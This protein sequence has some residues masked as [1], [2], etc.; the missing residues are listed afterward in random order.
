MPAHDRLFVLT[1]EPAQAH[2]IELLGL[3]R[4]DTQVPQETDLRRWAGS[5]S[6]SVPTPVC[7]AG[8]CSA[9]P[10]PSRPD[11]EAPSTDGCASAACAWSIAIISTKSRCDA[12]WRRPCTT[13]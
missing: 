5:P 2:H 12:T 7:R 1:L 10:S 13:Y 8:A 3:D 11:A 9:W 6:L 4:F